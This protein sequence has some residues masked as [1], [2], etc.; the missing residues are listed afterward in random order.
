MCRLMQILTKARVMA[1]VLRQPKVPLVRRLHLLQ[2]ALKNPWK[3]TIAVVMMMMMIPEMM[4]LPVLPRL[5]RSPPVLPK[6]VRNPPVLPRLVR[7]LP[8][9]PKLVLS[10]LVLLKLLPVLPSPLV[11]L[12]RVIEIEGLLVLLVLPKPLICL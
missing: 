7:N 3:K 11:V 10:L 2:K 6:L 1:R 5:V 8:V 4:N 12:P 9:L